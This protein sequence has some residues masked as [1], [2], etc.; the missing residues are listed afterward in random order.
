[1]TACKSSPP[2]VLLLS[3]FNAVVIGAFHIYGNAVSSCT[4]SGDVAGLCQPQSENPEETQQ[5]W[6]EEDELK[7]KQHPAAGQSVHVRSGQSFGFASESCGFYLQK[8]RRPGWYMT[9]I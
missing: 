4:H 6:E 1:M 7:N 2:R 9:L 3:F 5:L 8:E